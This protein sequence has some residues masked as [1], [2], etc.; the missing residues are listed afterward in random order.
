MALVSL[1]HVSRYSPTS[2]LNKLHKTKDFTLP[3]E[4]PAPKTKKVR[5]MTFFL[6]LG[7]LVQVAAGI[8]VIVLGATHHISGGI[9]FGIAII[10]LYPLVWAYMALLALILKEWLKYGYSP[11]KA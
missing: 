3:L 8:L 1:M 10:V 4:D 5:L 6:S 7:M 9:F 11:D 2:Y